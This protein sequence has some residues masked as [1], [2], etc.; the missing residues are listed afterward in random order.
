M[1]NGAMD[2]FIGLVEGDFNED[3]SA[4]QIIVGALITAIPFVGGVVNI[5]DFIANVC[6]VCKKPDDTWAW[7]ALAVVLLAFIP[8]VGGVLKGAFGIILKPLRK[9]GKHAQEALE[10]MLAV[11]RG[12]GFG[13]PVKYLKALPWSDFSAQATKHFNGLMDAL[14]HALAELRQRWLFK[15]LVPAD[16]VAR[17]E[18]VHLEILKLKS[19]G[20]DQIPKAF[21]TLRAQ[22]D[23]LLSHAKPETAKVQSGTQ[24]VIKHSERPL[25]RA[26]YEVRDALLKKDVDAMKAAGKSEHEIAQHAV[27][28]RQKLQTDIRAQSDKDLMDVIAVKRNTGIY[29]HPDGPNYKYNGQTGKWDYQQKDDL[30]D[31]FVTRSKTDAEVTAS[32]MKSGGDEIPWDKV[33]EYNRAKVAGDETT[34][35]RLLQAIDTAVNSRK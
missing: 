15:K 8:G 20:N 14:L 2:W 7:V 11:M 17:L 1:S 29:A 24:T 6:K 18:Q 3:P 5:R 22:V 27:Q 35:K 23:E 21:K 25:L 32:A 34:A 4:S 12:A 28:A 26:E 13:D 19:M 31:K 30:L 9:G 16:V 33:L 10:S